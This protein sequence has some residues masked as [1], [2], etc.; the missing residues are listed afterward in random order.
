MKEV[1]E[2][3]IPFMNL[4][5]KFDPKKIVDHEFSGKKPGYDA[6][7]VDRFLDE[8]VTDYIAMEKFKK[9]ANLMIEELDKTCKLY[10][11]R[12]NEVEVKNVVLNEKL[13]NISDNVD[14]SLSNIDLLKRISLLEQALFK[15]GVDPSKIK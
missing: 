3:I 14:A 9:E 7:Q 8:I 10:K 5:L 12:L 4:N 11:S 15:A 2:R 1:H 13:K 6:L